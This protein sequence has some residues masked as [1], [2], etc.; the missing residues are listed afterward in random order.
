MRA[1]FDQGEGMT[2][3]G[4]AAVFLVFVLA[5][6]GAPAGEIRRIS[7]DGS[8]RSAGPEEEIGKDGLARIKKLSEPILELYPAPAR[9]GRGTVVVMPGGGYGALAV[10][11]EG[12]KVAKWLNEA[13][14]DAVILLY[15]VGAGPETRE[16]ALA[17]AKAGL[18]LVRSRGA[19]F[20]L[21]PTKI[22]VIG[23]SAGG[24]LSA[25]LAHESGAGAL[26]FV[27]LVY[28]AYLEEN[29][30]CRD[31]VSPVSGPVFLYVA[32]DDK[33]APASF[34]YAAAC[35][36]NGIRCDFHHP[37]LGGH[38]FGLKPGR[39]ESVRDWPEK[40]RQFLADLN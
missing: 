2:S 5:V 33:H 13:G 30:K 38:G 11:H 36:A 14:W 7:L 32:E 8:P 29:G 25:R 37:A 23:F 26:H 4:C 6:G 40:F 18:Q 9:P 16:W 35:V 24:H 12:R 20:Q 28:P 17:D 3:K 1:R 19:E 10:E 31:D 15:R 27:G 22:G 39:P 21:S 34:A